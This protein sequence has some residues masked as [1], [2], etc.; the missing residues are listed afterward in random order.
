MIKKKEKAPSRISSVGGL[1]KSEGKE[2]RK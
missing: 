1:E 2:V